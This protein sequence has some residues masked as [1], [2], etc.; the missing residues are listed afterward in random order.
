MIGV[1]EGPVDQVL[2]ADVLG[3]PAVGLGGAGVGPAVIAR[4]AA[5]GRVYLLVDRDRAGRRARAA[6]VAALGTRVNVAA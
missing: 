5:F 6:F 3:L 4:F 2:L 1:V